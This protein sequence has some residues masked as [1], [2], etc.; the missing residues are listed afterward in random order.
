[1][2]QSPV[3]S[4]RRTEPDATAPAGNDSRQPDGRSKPAHPRL[5]PLQTAAATA[6][7]FTSLVVLGVMTGMVPMYSNDEPARLGAASTS[8]LRSVGGPVPRHAG[9]LRLDPA[10]IITESGTVA[11]ALRLL[12]SLL[13]ATTSSSAAATPADTVT[14]GS[15]N[16]PANP[17]AVAPTPPQRTVGRVV[18]QHEHEH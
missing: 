12:S 4:A 2:S 11:L 16:I 15:L 10:D 14:P 3:L 17:G 9:P 7:I 5:S 1:M 8:P 13:G 18:P 6:V